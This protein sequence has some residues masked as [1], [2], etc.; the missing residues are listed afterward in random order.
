MSLSAGTFFPWYAGK[1]L[2]ES[3]QVMDRESVPE[4]LRTLADSL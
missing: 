1:T 3:E 4:Y 2:F